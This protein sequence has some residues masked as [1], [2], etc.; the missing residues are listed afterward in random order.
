MKYNTI[1]VTKNLRSERVTY[2]VLIEGE[3]NDN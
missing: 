2:S 1:Y 3:K